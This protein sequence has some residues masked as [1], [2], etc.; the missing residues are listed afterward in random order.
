MDTDSNL[1]HN[2]DYVQGQILATQALILALSECVV[3]PRFVA[4]AG[5]HVELLRNRLLLSPRDVADM[6]LRALGDVEAWLLA[7]L[8]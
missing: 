1:Y 4:R 7:T 3:T 8:C 5:H 2:P 6:R